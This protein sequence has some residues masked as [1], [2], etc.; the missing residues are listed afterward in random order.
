MLSP[1]VRIARIAARQYGV[2]TFDQALACGFT[3]DTI[4]YRLKTGRWRRLHRAVYLL[5]GTEMSFMTRAQGGVLAGGPAAVTSFLTAGVLYQAEGLR[6]SMIEITVPTSRSA[7]IKDLVVHHVD[8][9]RADKAEVMRI[10]VTTPSRTIIDLASSLEDDPLED[11]LHSFVRRRMVDPG[12]LEERVQS[13]RRKGLS[14]PKKLLK[15]LQ[16]LTFDNV[17]GSGRENKVRR[18]LVRAGVEAPTRQFTITDEYGNFV[19]RPDLCYPNHRVYIEYDGGHHMEPKRRARDLERQNQL[20]AI[21]WRPLVFIDADFKKPPA[22]IVAKV[23]RSMR[24][25]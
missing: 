19:A 12:A 9:P 17:S 6:P 5:V 16:G 23:R 13:M 21:G 24:F 2:F 22:A 1:D 10:P 25:S 7:R 18:L 11:A 15:L 20:S 3:P 8:L 4:A 14:G